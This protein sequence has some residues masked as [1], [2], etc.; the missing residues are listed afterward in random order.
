MAPRNLSEVGQ[1]NMYYTYILF[2]SETKKYYVGYSNDLKKRI[3]DHVQNQV[4]STK[5]NSY[6]LIWYCGFPSKRQALRFETYLKSSSGHAFR[7]KHL[8]N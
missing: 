2:N 4:N 5:N 6:K 3:K 1:K 7:K 8:L